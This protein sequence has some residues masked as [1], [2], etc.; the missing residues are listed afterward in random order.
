LGHILAGENNNKNECQSH[1]D[2]DPAAD[3]N[4]FSQTLSLLLTPI[5]MSVHHYLLDLPSKGGQQAYIFRCSKMP[6]PFEM[7]DRSSAFGQ[8]GMLE[9]HSGVCR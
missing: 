1:I 3:S 2:N 4:L 7:M 9:N 6:T 5:W 8:H